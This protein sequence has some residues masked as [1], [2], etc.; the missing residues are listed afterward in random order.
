[1]NDAEQAFL[2]NFVTELSITPRERLRRLLEE[3]FDEGW[4]SLRIEYETQAKNPS[5]PITDRNPWRATR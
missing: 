2:D 1:M 3:Q 5:H 4:H